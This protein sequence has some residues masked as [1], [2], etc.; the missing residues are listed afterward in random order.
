M[1]SINR[2]I[3]IGNLGADPETRYT[4]GGDAVCNIRLATTDKWKDKDSGETRENTEWH[5]VV[6]YR[7]LA[8]VASEYLA[9]GSQVYIEGR[10]K[11]RKWEDK[12]GQTRYTTQIEALEMQMLGKREGSGGGGNRRQQDD[13]GYAPAPRQEQ[14][15]R[16]QQRQQPSFEDLGDDIPF[17]SCDMSFDLDNQVSKRMRRYGRDAMQEVW[18]D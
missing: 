10:L 17:A 5:S 13:D 6:F 4:A 11:T 12:D 18:R 16:P 9:K 14:Q 3:L 8:E 7:R 1:A 2:V 15:R